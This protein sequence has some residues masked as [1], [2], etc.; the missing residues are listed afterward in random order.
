MPT[1]NH[2]SDQVPNHTQLQWRQWYA[3][4]PIGCLSAG[5]PY[6]STWTTRSTR[7]GDPHPRLTH[8]SSLYAECRRPNAKQQV[9]SFGVGCKMQ[10][11]FADMSLL[12]HHSSSVEVLRLLRC[13]LLGAS[14]RERCLSCF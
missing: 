1:L 5:M 14:D 7:S 13:H 2:S 12:F 9:Y 8:G 4:W 6:F 11:A 3:D 10:P